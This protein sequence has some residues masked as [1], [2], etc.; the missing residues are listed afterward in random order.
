M[1]NL[2]INGNM[3]DSHVWLSGYF[4]TNA[5]RLPI[6]PVEVKNPWNQGTHKKAKGPAMCLDSLIN[7]QEDTTSKGKKN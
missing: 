2:S 6:I 4:N 3:C 5:K 7:H 1:G